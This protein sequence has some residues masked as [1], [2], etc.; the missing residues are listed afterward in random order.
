MKIMVTGAA[1][2]IGS[3]LCGDLLAQGHEVVGVDCFVPYYPESIKRRNLEPLLL[4][5]EFRFVP[6][7]LRRTLPA[8]LI[9]GVEAIIHLAAMPGL[10]KSWTD[11][12]GYWTCNVQATKNILE[13][14]EK[15][16]RPLKK[17]IYGSTSSVY[18]KFASGDEQMPTRPVS[19]YGITKLAGEFLCRAW[20]ENFNLPVVTLRFFSVYGPGQRP[21]MAYNLWIDAILDDKPIVLYGDGHQVRGN[22][23]V[24]D[25]VR[26]IIAALDA[27]PGEI[28]NIGGGEMVSML[29][30]LDVLSKIGGKTPEVRREDARPG[31]QRHTFADTAKLTRHLNWKPKVRLLEGLKAQYDWQQSL[32]EV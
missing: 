9:A 11:F 2:F 31:D 8:D 3:N 18:G 23:Y 28:Y 1:G 4:Q 19:P 13:A 12:D 15:L 25:C 7:D 27:T 6:H 24:K 14:T 30:I 29:D 10:V 17:L 16:D 26:A 20:M 32:R 21:D 5:K 22:T